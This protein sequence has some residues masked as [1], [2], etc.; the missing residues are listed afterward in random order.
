MKTH[1]KAST[2]E[3]ELREIITAKLRDE[4]GWKACGFAADIAADI[5]SSISPHEEIGS[6]AQLGLA[7]RKYIAAVDLIGDAVR[8]SGAGGAGDNIFDV[9]NKL[10][11]DEGEPEFKTVEQRKALKMNHCIQLEQP[12]VSGCFSNSSVMYP[13]APLDKHHRNC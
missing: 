6:L 12:N 3:T 2:V 1:F 7:S 9:A 5:A 13:H 4:M 8:A 10:M 11:S